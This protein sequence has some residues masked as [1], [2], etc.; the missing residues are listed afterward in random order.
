MATR[1]RSE[2]DIKSDV[3]VYGATSFVARHIFMYLIDVGPSLPKTLK[4]TLAGRN[5]EKL[6]KVLAEFEPKVKECGNCS[7]LEVLV[8]NSTDHEAL[9]KMA[10]RTRVVINCAGPFASYSSGVVAACATTGCDYVD[11]TGEVGWAGDM[12]VKYGP[13]AAKSDSRIIS[14]CGYDSIPSDMAIFAA[15]DALRSK[16]EL[17][18]SGGATSTDDAAASEPVE[19]DFARTFH[20]AMGGIGGGTLATMKHMELDI[21]KCLFND[22][23]GSFWLRRMPFFCF[24]PLVLTHPES[25]RFNPDYEAT[26]NRL[27]CTEWWN[28]LPYLHTIFK[29]GVSIP[30][31][32]AAA[33]AKVVHASALALNYGPNFKYYERFC[34]LGFKL[35]LGFGLF[36]VIPCFITLWA[37]AVLGLLIRLPLF[38]DI[39]LKFIIPPGSGLSDDLCKRGYAEVY[40]EVK[41]PFKHPETKER[42]HDRVSCAN[43]FIQFEGDPGNS[44]T[45]QC[46][47]E[48]A[49]SLV[50]N[51]KELPPNSKDGFGTPAELLG[52][53]LLNRLKNSK[54][55][56][57][58]VKTNVRKN[59]LVHEF[60]V[61]M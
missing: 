4:I 8:A 61:Y 50:L 51:R 36:G 42:V 33:N 59:V 37:I 13:A 53:V 39:V 15:V 46:V 26:R 16:L 43:S 41:A 24:D 57:V 25:I 17:S 32:M 35:T 49:L 6:K 60:E 22:N 58:K 2:S 19:I 31:F 45:A 27:A 18:G 52:P 56:P 30:F 28:L 14:L 21:F 44:I 54:V 3:T 48:S 55:R 7:V 47:V 12:R 40:A 10:T 38:G 9:K 29:Q 5:K 23:G 11:I 34:P 20:S 1:E